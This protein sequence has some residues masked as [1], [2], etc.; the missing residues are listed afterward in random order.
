MC[1]AG[2]SYQRA[3]LVISGEELPPE[4]CSKSQ[5]KDIWLQN[6]ADMDTKPGSTFIVS[7]TLGEVAAHISEPPLYSFIN[8]A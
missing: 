2:F 6:Q 3:A 8:W 7:V 5:F 1:V 4:K